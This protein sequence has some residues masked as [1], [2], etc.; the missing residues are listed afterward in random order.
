[1]SSFNWHWIHKI[2][3]GRGEWLTLLFSLLLALS[4]WTIHNLSLRYSAYLQYNVHFRT[5]IEGRVMEADA[6]D[7][8]MLRARASGY[9]LMS[10]HFNDLITLNLESRYFHQISQGSDTFMVYVSEIKG[11]LEKVLLEDISSIENFTTEVV[12]VILPKIETKKVPVIAQ[13]QVDYLPQYMAVSE[14]LLT[15]DSILISGE[16]DLVERVDA[17][18]TK[19]ISAK[20]VKK[21]FQGVVGIIPVDGLNTS[22]SQI[23]YSQ[24]VGRYIEQSLELPL[25]VINV[26]KDKE[27]L[28]L[29]TKVTVVYRQL[30]SSHRALYPSDFTCV[31]NYQDAASAINSQVV[32]HLV[33]VPE[34]IYSV[35]FDPP[36]VDCIILD[37]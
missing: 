3:K 18:Y 20:K 9:N 15:P 37:K 19:I 25:E 1:M 6:E 7:A 17:V 21:R 13:T 22:Q 12:R 33:K 31:I 10:Q 26:P 4:I 5:N 24:E 28:P 16:D 30:L 8:I 35:T 11:E 2:A 34:G 32:P 27:L 23:Y 29:S 36:Y 14:M